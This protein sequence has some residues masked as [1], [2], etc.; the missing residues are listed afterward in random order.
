MGNQVRPQ[1][2]LRKALW[3]ARDLLSDRIEGWKEMREIVRFMH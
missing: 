3:S 2:R 1:G